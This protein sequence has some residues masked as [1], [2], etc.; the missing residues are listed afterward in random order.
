[1][2]TAKIE[3]LEDGALALHP[4]PDQLIAWGRA[5]GDEPLADWLENIADDAATALSYDE[6]TWPVVIELKFPFDFGKERI[7][8]IEMRRGKLGDIKGIKIGGEI[9][10]EQLMLIGS[11]LSGKSLAIIER[12]DAE[13]AGEVTAIALDFYGRCLGTGKKRSR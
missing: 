7:D 6:R 2:T 13:D 3:V 4:S 10:M 12:L 9:P 11:R 8:K 5:A 1:M